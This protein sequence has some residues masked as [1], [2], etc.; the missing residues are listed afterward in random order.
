MTAVEVAI[1]GSFVVAGLVA[2]KQRPENH[3][4]R[5]MVLTGVAWFGREL[6]DFSLNLFLALI[7]HQVVVFPYGQARSR[8]ERVLVRS[9]YALA[10]GGYVLSELVEATNDVLSVVG[11]LMLLA[12]GFVVVERWRAATAPARRALAPVIWAGL[13]V[14]A[15]AGASIARDYLDLSLSA[16]AD[17]ALDRAELVYIAIPL[18]F[19]AGLLREQL[20]RAGLGQLVVELSG[21]VTSPRRVRDALARALGDPSLDIAFWLPRARRYVDLEGRPADPFAGGGGRTAMRLQRRGEPLAALVYDPSLLDD[22][23]LIEAAG[24]AASLALENA[25]LQTEP[26]AQLELRRA[27]DP[28]SLSELTARELEVL[29]LIAEGRTDRG[30]AQQLFVTPKTVESHVRS[31]LRK[32]DLPAEATENR[33][34]HAVL[35]FLRARERT[36][37]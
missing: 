33:R 30:I 10:V 17:T 31:I 12:I 25:R 4:G 5:L 36:P 7:A 15:V 32:L 8:L 37:S 27:G 22:P 9:I 20:Q 3:A 1:G 26:R 34:V 16:A 18:A 28:D 24:A 19:L 14:L 21:D 11:A 13:P 23:A 29:A 6:G 2:W 35:A